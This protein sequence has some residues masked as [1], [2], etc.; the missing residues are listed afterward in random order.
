LNEQPSAQ[1]STSISDLIRN[2]TNYLD[3]AKLISLF[4]A[5]EP[6][7]YKYPAI[8]PASFSKAVHQIAGK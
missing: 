2:L 7:L 3:P 1:P 6:E 5:I 8:D 4:E